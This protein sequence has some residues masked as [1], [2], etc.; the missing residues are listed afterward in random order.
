M[1]NGWFKES[2]RHSLASRG[3]KTRK[4]LA[5]FPKKRNTEAENRMK[6]LLNRIEKG[7]RDN[8]LP[9]LDPVELAKRNLIKESLGE[10]ELTN[11]LDTQAKV[12]ELTV[13]K[14]ELKGL[15]KPI[16]QTKS[17]IKNANKEVAYLDDQIAASKANL[18]AAKDSGDA[19]H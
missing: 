18:Q 11:F 8:P 4:Y 13:K 10:D 17:K 6:E 7:A 14:K 3:I 12:S 1:R 19:S 5:K 16:K 15:T 2:Y 9:T